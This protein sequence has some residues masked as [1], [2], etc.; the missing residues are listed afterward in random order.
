MSVCDYVDL[1]LDV[2]TDLL[3]RP[4]V[5]DLL[6]DALGAALGPAG[7][8]VTVHAT[9]PESVGRDMARVHAS[10]QACGTTGKSSAGTGTIVALVVQSGREAVTELLVTVPVADERSVRM[11]A[12]ATHRFLDE[13]AGRLITRTAV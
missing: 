5:D 6:A 13:L 9:A 3:A 7:G 10:W 1:P 4:D 11:S 12:A 8:V 2:I